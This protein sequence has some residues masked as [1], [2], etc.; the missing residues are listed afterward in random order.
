MIKLGVKEALPFARRATITAIW[1][2]VDNTNPWPIEALSVSP[3]FQ[4]APNFN[5]FH[6]GSGIIPDL[7]PFK[8]ILNFSPNPSFRPIDAMFSIP[9]FWLNS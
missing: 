6:L 2:G 7:R 4:L 5:F 3:T 9:T 8:P 1:R